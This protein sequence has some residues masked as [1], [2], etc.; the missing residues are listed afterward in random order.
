MELQ[1]LGIPRKDYVLTTKLFWGGGGPNDKGLNRKH[2]IEGTKVCRHGSPFLFARQKIWLF[3]L[4]LKTL[5]AVCLVCA[6]SQ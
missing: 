6:V 3:C 4:Q 5:A 1:E 2:I